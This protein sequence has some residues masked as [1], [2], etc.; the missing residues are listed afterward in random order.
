MK[1]GLVLVEGQTEEQ[2][3]SHVLQPYLW[4]KSSLWITPRVLV[5]K[6]VKSG[7]AFKGGI[8]NFN[9]VQR[10]IARL[11]QDRDAA[12]IT[13]LFDYYGL[14]SRFPGMASRPFGTP[15]QRVEHVQSA[16]GAAIDDVRFLPFLALHEFEAWLFCDLGERLEWV[17]QGGDLNALRAVRQSVTTPEDI[18]EGY[19]TAPSRRVMAACPGYQKPLHGPLAVME[20][21]V[22]TIRAQCPHFNEW[23]TQL[24]SI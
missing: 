5:T 23:L 16:F 14:P 2:F 3:V 1:R 22:D 15:K 9:Q 17:Y 7:P 10:D 4:A 24:E 11:L 21:G 8:L 20:M 12:V 19:H 18:N 13:T 6:L